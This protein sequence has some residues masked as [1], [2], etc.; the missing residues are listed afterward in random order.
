MK[1]SFEVAERHPKIY[2]FRGI[3]PTF[4]RGMILQGNEYDYYVTDVVH[5]NTDGD[6]VQV[7]TCL[8]LSAVITLWT[9][10]S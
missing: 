2:V 5:S 1:V 3:E 7:L 4:R 8:V 6:C 10:A 9:T